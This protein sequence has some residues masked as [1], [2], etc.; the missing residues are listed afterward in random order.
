MIKVTTPSG[1]VTQMAGNFSAS[2]IAGAQ[3]KPATSSSR[4]PASSS[5]AG[6]DSTAARQSS[7]QASHASHLSSGPP[8]LASTPAGRSSATTLPQTA[9]TAAAASSTHRQTASGAAPQ[10][11]M[12]VAM[13]AADTSAGSY[14]PSTPGVASVLAASGAAGGRRPDTTVEFNTAIAYVNKIKS[15]FKDKPDT[16]KQFLEI[17]QTYQRDGKEI[18]EVSISQIETDLS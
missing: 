9:P 6:Q 3:D 13:P 18:T 7:T 15:R 8:T 5:R 12:S 16:Y 2:A 4:N 1:H 14:G 10:G 11:S 17:L